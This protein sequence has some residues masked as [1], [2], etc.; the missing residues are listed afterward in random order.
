MRV[1]PDQGAVPPYRAIRTANRTYVEYRN[2][3]AERELYNLSRDRFQL[4]SRHA[5]PDSAD[6]RQELAAWLATLEECAAE[7][8]REAE[9]GPPA[10]AAAARRAAR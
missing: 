4:R 3:A 5:D 6:E 7:T 10:A 2:A 1:L 8:C 9:N